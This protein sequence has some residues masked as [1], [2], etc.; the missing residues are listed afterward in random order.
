V[1]VSTKR[2][3]LP[4]AVEAYV[5]GR[6]TREP[7]L[8]KRLREET[9]ALPEARMQI[10]PDQGALLA[11]LVR[12]LGAR[13]ALEIGTF[14]GMSALAV[15]AALP[16]DGRLVTCDVSEEWTA[17]ARRYWKQA[18]LAHK[19]ELKLAPA[20]DTLRALERDRGAACFDFAFIDADKPTYDAYYETCLRLVRPGGLIA[21][22]NMLWGGA[23]ADP[24]N[25]ESNTQVIRALNLKIRDDPR[26]HAC[27]LTV[28]DG[29]MLAS[30]R[31][32]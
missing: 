15:A 32:R 30:P 31:L 22:D 3:L 1:V 19:I 20:S 5:A 27:L 2:S 29:V 8:L 11:L 9:A 16:E 24:S 4:D 6:I 12:L 25:Q 10:G 7:P 28:G 17:V 26:V 23:V 18:G 14:T 21:L 13:R